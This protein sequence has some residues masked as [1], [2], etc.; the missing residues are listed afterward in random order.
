MMKE[1]SALEEFGYPAQIL[2]YFASEKVAYKLSEILPASLV[3]L[4]LYVYDDV[5][6]QVWEGKLLEFF[7]VKASCCPGLPDIWVE[8]WVFRDVPTGDQGEIEVIRQRVGELKALAKVVR[9]DLQVQLDENI[10]S[11]F[12]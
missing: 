3:K 12:G 4:R 10:R 1:F 11:Q 7:E 6:F 9:I 5:E 2:F 8:Y